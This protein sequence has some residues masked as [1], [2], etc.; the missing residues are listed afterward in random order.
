VMLR[1]F[2]RL[3]AQSKVFSETGVVGQLYTIEMLL[4]LPLSHCG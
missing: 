1:Q 3:A 2:F 4:H